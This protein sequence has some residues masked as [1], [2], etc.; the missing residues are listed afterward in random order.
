MNPPLILTLGLHPDD[1]ARFERLRQQHFP[2]EHNRIPAHLTLFHHL[3]GEELASI[4]AN[5][6]TLCAIQP[7]FAV[8]VNGLRSLGRG[9]AYTLHAAPL[10]ALRAGIAR[11]WHGRLTPQDRQGWRPHVTIQNKVSPTEAAALLTAMQG[12]FTPFAIRAEALLLW[13]YQGGPWEL[14]SRHPFQS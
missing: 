10:A 1:Q 6:A 11:H 7:A 5:L 14:A 8:D 3:P 12:G 13:H 9:V 2:P 4:E